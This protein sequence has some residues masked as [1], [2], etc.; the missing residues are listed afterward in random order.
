MW[1]LAV[2][3]GGTFTDSVMVNEK[4]GEV[5]VAKEPT[6]TGDA[7]IGFTNT[8][9]TL[10][11]QGLGLS[12]VTQIIHASTLATNTLLE[13]KKETDTCLITTKGF[14]DVLEIQRQRRYDLFDIFIEKPKPVIPPFDFIMKMSSE[15]PIRFKPLKRFC[16]YFLVS[17]MT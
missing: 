17:G 15:N 12:Q 3:I 16:R 9:N 4:T 8:I 14:R 10:I 6:T 11:D 1:K 7:S 5:V 13:R 2:D